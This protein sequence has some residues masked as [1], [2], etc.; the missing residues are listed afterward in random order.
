MLEKAG[1]GWDGV[2]LKWGGGVGVGVGV[3][4]DGGE[5]EKQ[6]EL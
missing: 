2:L 3:G 5:V 1:E 4:V 6:L